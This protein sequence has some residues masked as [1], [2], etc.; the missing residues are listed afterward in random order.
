MAGSGFR[1][2]SLLDDAEE[3]VFQRSVAGDLAAIARDAESRAARGARAF[4]RADSGAGRRCAL[5]GCGRRVVNRR[6]GHRSVQ[7]CGEAVVEVGD[8]DAC[9]VEAF[10][11]GRD[12]DVHQR[13][14]SGRGASL[15]AVAAGFT[16]HFFPALCSLA[17]AR[18][19]LSIR[20]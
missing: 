8:R 7:A 17:R 14:K 20:A 6:T 19:L 4:E 18:P 5:E 12:S 9:A 1:R 2:R 3:K 10:G 13:T 16:G 11:E 15:Q